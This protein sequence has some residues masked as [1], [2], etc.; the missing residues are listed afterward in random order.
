MNRKK[1]FWLKIIITVISFVVVI[2][3][4]STI[5][6]NNWSNNYIDLALCKEILYDLSVGVFSAMILVWFIDEINERIQ[7][8]T[9]QAKEIAEITRAS[10]LLQLYIER[11]KVFF[12]CVTTPMKQRDFINMKFSAD[13]N[14]K[15][16][17]ELHKSTLLVSEGTFDSSIESFL[18][19]ESE[20]KSE[21]EATIR[22]IDFEYYTSIREHLIRF[23]EASLKYN[24]KNAILEAKKTTVADKTLDV[25][26]EE[27]LEKYADEFYQDIKAGK[28]HGANIMHPY[29][30]L[31]EMMKLQYDAI[32]K[33]EQELIAIQL[34]GN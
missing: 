28:K 4:K 3:S 27:Y 30:Y 9:S 21:I 8:K 23:L 25:E 33:Y 20:L 13:F 10:K 31:Y 18:R 32:N 15:D 5:D 24:Q 26:I 6:W 11:Y 22:A 19:A 16:M 1:F 29:I 14:I 7:E 34:R 2:L 17:R 12:Y